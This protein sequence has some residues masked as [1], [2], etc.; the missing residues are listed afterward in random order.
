MFNKTWPGHAQ[1]KG[2]EL[3]FFF[4]ESGPT[5]SPSQ[6]LPGM[7]RRNFFPWDRT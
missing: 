6:T 3:A 5:F 1:G 4:L 2:E 7:V